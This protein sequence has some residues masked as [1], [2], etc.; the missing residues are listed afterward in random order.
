MKAV[1]EKRIITYT[2]IFINQSADFSA[3]TLWARRERD[4]IFNML[5]QNKTKQNK[6]PTRE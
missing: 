5:K 4:D 3:E 1:R 6:V 2:A